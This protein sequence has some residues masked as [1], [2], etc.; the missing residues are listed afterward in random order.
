MISAFP[1]D[2]SCT[3]VLAILG[4][5]PKRGDLKAQMWQ[6]I[7]W[8]FWY[9]LVSFLFVSKTYALE[10]V[11]VLMVYPATMHMIFDENDQHSLRKRYLQS[12]IKE[13]FGKTNPNIF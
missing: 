5:Y 4:M 6:I 3:A 8:T 2:W 12:I 13:I 11:G 9:G 7:Q 10:L 1:A